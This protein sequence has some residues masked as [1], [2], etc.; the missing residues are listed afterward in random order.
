[1]NYSCE[2]GYNDA[3]GAQA[4]AEMQASGE[5][6]YQEYLAALIDRKQ[7]ELFGVEICLEY[8]N[9]KSFKKSGLSAAECLPF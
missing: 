6:D 9:S 4:E 3:M 5:Q 2:A 8:L 7:Y 1:M